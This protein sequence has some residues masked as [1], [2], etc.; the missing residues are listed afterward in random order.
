MKLCPRCGG[1]HE[2]AACPSRDVPREE[3]MNA[4]VAIEKKINRTRFRDTRTARWAGTGARYG[5]VA[6]NLLSLSMAIGSSSTHASN[7]SAA[8]GADFLG[9]LL[10]SVAVVAL[11]GAGVGA[12]TAILVL[13]VLRPIYVALFRSIDEWEQEYGE[14]RPRLPPRPPTP[15]EE[16]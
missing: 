16:L 2:G 13:G 15:K 6:A 12:G 4:V 10:L 3:A 9:L 5:F 14:G 11:L 7:R 1:T 8:T